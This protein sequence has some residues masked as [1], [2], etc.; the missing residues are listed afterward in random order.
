MWRDGITATTLAMVLAIGSADAA[1]AAPDAR[2]LAAAT[3]ARVD[4][5]ALLEHIVN[6]DSGTGDAVGAAKVQ[7]LLIPRL[8]AIGATIE[9]TPAEAAGLGDNVVARIEGDGTARILIIAHVDTVFPAGTAAQRQYRSDGI[10]AYGPGVSDEKGGAIEAVVALKLLHDLGETHFKRITVLLETSE[11][12]GSPGTRH[13]I[14]SLVH[15]ADVELNME[16]GDRA[17]CDHGMA[18]GLGDD[19][20]HRTRPRG[21]CRRRPAGRAQRRDRADPPA[22]DDRSVPAVGRRHH[23][24]SDDA[25]GR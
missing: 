18:Q 24:Q 16:P 25:E 4:Q 14:A 2:V 1:S 19:P 23:R 21:A 20:P 11:E 13:L 5:L 7:A 10:R 15:D 8:R 3:A 6:I 9:T 17:R 22:Q 12:Q